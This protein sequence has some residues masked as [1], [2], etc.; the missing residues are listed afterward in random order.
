[1]KLWDARQ[2]ILVSSA[3][4]TLVLGKIS[5]NQAIPPTFAGVT[6]EVFDQQTQHRCAANMVLNMFFTNIYS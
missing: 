3:V 2:A 4:Q 1:M 5:K 6:H